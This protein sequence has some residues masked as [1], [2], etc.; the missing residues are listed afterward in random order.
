MVKIKKQVIFLKLQ[1]ASYMV[2]GGCAGISLYL[3]K[4]ALYGAVLLLGPGRDKYA[5][6]AIEV[7][8]STIPEGRSSSYYY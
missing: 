3:A 4:Y 8:L 7:D 5:A 1:M 2:I 6:A